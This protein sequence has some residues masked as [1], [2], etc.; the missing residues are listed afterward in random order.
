MY[1]KFADEG[2]GRLLP[3]LLG[4]SVFFLLI[5]YSSWQITDRENGLKVLEPAVARITEVETLLPR[6]REQMEEQVA[7][8]DLE[9]VFIPNYPILVP[10][11]AD[12]LRLLSD[13]ELLA[14]VKRESAELT[15]QHGLNVFAIDGSIEGGLFSGEGAMR[16]TFGQITEGRHD[17]ITIAV[18]VLVIMT[19]LLVVAQIFAASGW[20]RLVSIGAMVAAAAIPSLILVALFRFG[21]STLADDQ[22]D[23]LTQDLLDIWRKAVSVP[24]RND[25]AVSVFGLVLIA[26]GW[27]GAWLSGFL[28]SLMNRPRPV[29]EAEYEQ[30]TLPPPMA[31]GR[32]YLED[33]YARAAAPPART[34]KPAPAPQPRGTRPA[35]ATRR[36]EQFR[37]PAPEAQG[38]PA[39]GVNGQA[40]P[41]A[42]QT[43]PAL[44]P[45]PAQPSDAPVAS[46]AEKSGPD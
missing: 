7:E 41:P 13:E 11:T 45:P 29:P 8:E 2:G 21:I 3:F 6:M 18:A 14:Y 36:T 46:D 44:E 30:E 25:M 40:E 19:A 22:N 24:F 39:P 15:Y 34:R 4:L 17:Q 5:A 27:L 9:V 35:R 23:P 31:G 32:Q 20:G 43:T 28:G 10:I 38:T 26:L 33:P 37:R 16:L 12:Q 1:D 42:A